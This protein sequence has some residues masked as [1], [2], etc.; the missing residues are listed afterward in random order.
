M[1]SR[2]TSRNRILIITVRKR[3]DL[4][5][6]R[7]LVENG[8]AL[9]HIDG[10]RDAAINI[11]RTPM[12]LVLLDIAL[13]EASLFDAMTNARTVFQGPLIVLADMNDESA[14]IL[15][16]EL[17]ADD[18]VV[19]PVSPLLLSAKIGAVLRRSGYDEKV[20]NAETI[21]IGGLR[22]DA[23]RRDVHLH[24]H[25]IRLTTVE[26]DLLWYLARNAGSTVSRNDI[27]RSVFMREYNGIDVA[28]C[29]HPHSDSQSSQFLARII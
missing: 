23:A 7:R 20:N 2:I 3:T 12:E 5:L 8:Y 29:N 27:Q 19:R 14:H 13:E 9:F 28:A 17:G 4:L 16:L 11:F 18:F 24:G 10:W 21:V 6:S 25:A 1:N 15:A 22:I 26:F